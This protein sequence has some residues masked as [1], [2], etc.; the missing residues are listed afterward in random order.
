M[1]HHATRSY[2][3]KEAYLVLQTRNLDGIPI[4][5]IYEDNSARNFRVQTERKWTLVSLLSLITHPATYTLCDY[6][7]SSCPS[8]RVAAVMNCLHHYFIYY[9]LFPHN[10]F[11]SFF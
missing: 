2:L 5:I 7:L 6:F 11:I 10:A 9:N 8:K 1:K 3:R 4:N